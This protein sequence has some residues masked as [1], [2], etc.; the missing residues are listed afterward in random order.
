[1]NRNAPREDIVQAIIDMVVVRI[2]AL[3]NEK[4]RPEKNNSVLVGGLAKNLAVVRG[5]KVRSG[6]DFL[7]PENPEYVGALGAALIAA[8]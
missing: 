1:M 8:G 5:L 4:I 2:N 7:V 3:L 6:V